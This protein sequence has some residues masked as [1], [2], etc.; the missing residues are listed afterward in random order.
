PQPLRRGI[1]PPIPLA[2]GSLQCSAGAGNAG[3]VG[4]AAGSMNGISM[5]D[6]ACV[7]RGSATKRHKGLC[8][9]GNRLIQARKFVQEALGRRGNGRCGHSLPCLRGRRDLSLRAHPGIMYMIG[10]RTTLTL[11]CRWP[12]TAF[13]AA[14]TASP[15]LRRPPPSPIRRMR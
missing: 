9:S 11:L 14:S 5:K 6:M 15:P 1:L 4:I 13:S 12:V 7:L 8:W 10:A 3:G 2:G